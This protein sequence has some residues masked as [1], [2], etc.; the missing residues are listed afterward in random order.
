MAD[1]LPASGRINYKML[2]MPTKMNPDSKLAKPG[3]DGPRLVDNSLFN[4]LWF[5]LTWFCAVLGRETLLPVAVAML[6]LHLLLVPRLYRELLQLSSIAAIGL[7]IDASLST[8]GVFQFANGVLV[9]AWLGCV[10]L[11]FAAVLGRSLAYLSSRPVLTSLL[12]AVVVPFNYWVGARAGAVSFGYPLPVTLGLL[13]LIW[14]V[15][16]PMLYRLTALIASAADN[17]EQT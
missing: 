7:G 13:A 1:P 2:T 14:A 8:A 4:A 12:G 16:L 6:F 10:W 17:G 9:P 15:L 5:Q 11:A 3:S